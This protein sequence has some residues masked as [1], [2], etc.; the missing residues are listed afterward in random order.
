MRGR[1]RNFGEI[2]R[3][4][5]MGNMVNR[6]NHER[7]AAEPEPRRDSGRQSGSDESGRGEN[8]G[9]MPHR[10]QSGN[11]HGHEPEP[12]PEQGG[13]S[14]GHGPEPKPH[15]EQG[16]HGYGPEPQP[17][18]GQGAHGHGRGPE[19]EP[20]PHP[21]QGGHGPG[22]FN[23]GG[24][25]NNGGGDK[26]EKTKFPNGYTQ[27]AYN[28]SGQSTFITKPVQN[29]VSSSSTPVI[30]ST[31]PGQTWSTNTLIPITNY[32]QRLSTSSMKP[33]VTG[34]I[35]SPSQTAT[36]TSNRTPF[37]G[38]TTQMSLSTTTTTIPLLT[39]PSS[40]TFN[41]P[42]ITDS[43]ETLTTTNA[44]PAN[45]AATQDNPISTPAPSPTTSKTFQQETVGYS[46]S[47]LS[48]QSSQQPLTTE[49]NQQQNVTVSTASSSRST[50][51]TS[52]PTMVV[53]SPSTDD[54]PPVSIT[55]S[56]PAT[57]ASSQST[58]VISVPTAASS[59][60]ATLTTLTSSQS[61][62]ATSVSATL[63]S[64]SS[65]TETSSQTVTA[66][67][68]KQTTVTSSSSLATSFSHSVTGTTP[69]IL[70]NSTTS[71]M[72]FQCR[73]LCAGVV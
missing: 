62:T 40:G 66:T 27:S 51:V 68:S 30:I 64:S 13:N 48:Q 36:A 53:T 58:L 42:I 12:H 61:T 54:F 29:P 71:E 34:S 57:T 43:T 26:N 56:P 63:T 31:L 11:R 28:V 41:T 39:L 60:S 50:S 10:G 72:C 33:A 59:S 7:P 65:A 47:T 52:Y 21:E 1:V 69:V 4:H 67:D 18:Q 49:S 44:I 38:N 25:G 8:H 19:P 55:N 6:G 3:G 46:S 17:Y 45:T 20:E 5:P 15:P 2:D 22:E 14:H 32:S 23:H 70:Q 16:G 9:N 35:S 73:Q 24:H 37:V